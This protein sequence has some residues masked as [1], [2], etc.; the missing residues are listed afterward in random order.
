VW[1]RLTIACTCL[2]RVGRAG[3][4]AQRKRLVLASLTGVLSTLYVVGLCV[5]VARNPNA[6]PLSLLNRL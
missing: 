4:P 5:F 1:R 2:P 6:S 3:T